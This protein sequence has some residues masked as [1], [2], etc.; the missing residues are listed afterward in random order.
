MFGW[1]GHFEIADVA[2]IFFVFL[3]C[4]EVV[5]YSSEIITWF[6]QPWTNLIGSIVS[7][8]GPLPS[9]PAICFNLHHQS[10][11]AMYNILWSFVLS[12]FVSPEWNVLWVVSNSRR[13]LG[14]KGWEKR[15]PLHCYTFETHTSYQIP[16]SWAQHENI[17][18]RFRTRGQV[19]D[20]ACFFHCSLLWQGEEARL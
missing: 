6:F 5:V 13:G 11:Q 10:G 16:H 3:L 8:R 1:T 15:Q 7:D 19:S 17:P 4:R 12:S 9:P 18:C 2:S 20:Q 14:I